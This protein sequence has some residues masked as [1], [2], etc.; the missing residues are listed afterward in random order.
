V[1]RSGLGVVA[2]ITADRASA[3]AS[4]RTRDRH[5]YFPAVAME[6]YVDR[7]LRSYNQ[8]STL[9]AGNA[10]DVLSVGAQRL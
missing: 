8:D 9:H 7:T 4:Y 1:G 10:V 6:V 3:C 5:L 2:V